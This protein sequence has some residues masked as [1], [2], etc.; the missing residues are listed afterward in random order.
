MKTFDLETL[1]LTTGSHEDREAGVCIMEA[2]AWF[3]NEPHSDHPRCA[4][5]VLTRF[6]IWLN[7]RFDDEQRQQLRPLIPRLVGTRDEAMEKMRRDY[8]F[9]ATLNVLIPIGLR[10][11]ADRIEPKDA[12]LAEKFRKQAR[13]FEE[14]PKIKYA[15]AL[16][17]ALA[18][19]LAVALALARARDLA[20]AVAVARDLALA[21][22]RDLAVD[23]ARALA[24]DLALAVA[25]AVAVDR[26]RALALDL[27][28]DPAGKKMV[29]QGAIKIFEHAID[30][31][32][33]EELGVV[34][35]VADKKVAAKKA[36]KPAAKKAANPTVKPAAKKAAKPVKKTLTA[37]SRKRIVDAMAKRMADRKAR[38]KA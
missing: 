25:R 28:P 5:P 29:W 33:D 12:E 26:A 36:I 38:A 34:A 14:L 11:L 1:K 24:L 10:N 30:L 20:L 27:A 35:P 3:A 18:R 8:L 16:A 13:Q 32:A 37:A 23:L 2:V 17:R 6:G 22:D 4:C 9:N 15:V 31:K 19:D 21:L 7:D